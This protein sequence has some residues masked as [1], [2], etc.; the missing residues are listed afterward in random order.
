MRAAPSPFLREQALWS[1]RP[2]DVGSLR[3]CAGLLVGTHDFTAFTPLRPSTSASSA[4]CWRAEWRRD[5]DLLEFWIEADTF[6]R[7]MVRVLVGTMLEVAGG[8][9]HLEQFASLLGGAERSQAG[10]T[11][12]AHGLTLEHVRY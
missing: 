6:M 9:R 5:G 12:E 1:P 2:L 11:A 4:T 3:R 8:R 7:H 10:P